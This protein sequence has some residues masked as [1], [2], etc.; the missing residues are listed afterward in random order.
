MGG[1]FCT[2]QKLIISNYGKKNSIIEKF[3]NQTEKDEYKNK[4]TIQTNKTIDKT[5]MSKKKTITSFDIK[6]K[7]SISLKGT[8]DINIILIG[9]K[10]TGKSCFIIK[11]VENRFENLYIP[12]VFIEKY[13]KQFIYKNKLFTL[14]FNVTP[15]VEEYKKDYSILYLNANFILLFCDISKN[16]SLERAKNYIKKEL[17]N[18]L[19]L[20]SNNSSNIFFIANK[21]DIYPE[22][23]NKFILDYCKK[24]LIN[25]FEI[26]VKT[27]I[28]INQVILKILELFY[29]IST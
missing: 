3:Q 20:Y 7:K 28:G 5:I 26:S 27:N 4:Q 13:S 8:S 19:L 21:I 9:E 11:L 16:D 24:H 14:H 10:Q 6:L 23:D 1:C 15:G 29:Q 22:Q 12:T 18:Q 17:K 2:E 25:F